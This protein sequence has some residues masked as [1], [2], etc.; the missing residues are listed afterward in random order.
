MAQAHWPERAFSGLTGFVL[1]AAMVLGGT[2]AQAVPGDATAIALAVPLLAWAGFRLAAARPIP[3]SAALAVTLAIAMLP[4]LYLIPLPADLWTAL[5]GRDRLTEVLSAAGLTPG[6]FPASI[7]PSMTLTSWPPLLVPLALFM[8]ALTLDLRHMHLV[9]AVAVAVALFSALLGF[10]QAS[11]IPERAIRFFAVTS[12]GPTGVYSNSNFLALTCAIGIALSGG[13][14]ARALEPEDPRRF[15]WLAAG[16]GVALV[17]LLAGALTTSRAGLLLCGLAGLGALILVLRR[18]GHA[19]WALAGAA[20]AALFAIFAVVQ[21]AFLSFI[22]RG[23]GIAERPIVWAGT[24]DAAGHFFPVGSGPGTFPLAFAM[25]ETPER[26]LPGFVNAAHNDYL[27]LWLEAGVPALALILIC[28]AAYGRA[29]VMLV[30]AR[31]DRSAAAQR[32]LPQFQA[33]ALALGLILLHAT[34]EFPLHVVAMLALSGLFAG[35]LTR[36]AYVP[37]ARA[38]AAPMAAR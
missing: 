6:W 24:W 33:A 21:L 16:G 18:L 12:T 38:S 11:A 5:P 3:H 27:Q 23:F 9:L 17:F 19:R 25:H 4:G 35:L 37:P 28:L 26:I 10:Q 8:A 14:T 34:V 20:I 32:M 30:R 36:V 31:N 2:S 1:G 22:N 29:V 13:L 7:D 15:L